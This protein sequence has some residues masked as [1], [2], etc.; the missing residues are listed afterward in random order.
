MTCLAADVNKELRDIT[1]VVVAHFIYQGILVK[2]LNNVQR[3]TIGPLR[4]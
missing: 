1:E 4:R 3:G 2:G